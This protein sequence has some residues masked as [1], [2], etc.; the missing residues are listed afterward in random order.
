MLCYKPVSGE[1]DWLIDLKKSRALLVPGRKHSLPLQSP[2]KQVTLQ[3]KT[4]K[5]NHSYSFCIML[6]CRGYPWIHAGLQGKLNLTY[7]FVRLSLITVFPHVTAMEKS[8]G[9]VG[10]SWDKITET[11]S[12]TE[13]N[14]NTMILVVDWIRTTTTT[15]LTTK[16]NLCFFQTQLGRACHFLEW[17]LL[18]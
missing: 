10:Y 18:Q 16:A 14:K 6:T 2:E 5:H 12:W 3:S 11:F 7:T 9:V 4:Q 17:S 13:K 15:L 1:A 8:G